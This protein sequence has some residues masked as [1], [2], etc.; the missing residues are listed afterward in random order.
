MIPITNPGHV[1]PLLYGI[2]IHCQFCI[3]KE[4]I[5]NAYPKSKNEQRFNPPT[6][7]YSNG[8]DPGGFPTTIVTSWVSASFVNL[9]RSQNQY[10]SLVIIQNLS[11]T[12]KTQNAKYLRLDLK[13]D[14]HSLY[15]GVSSAS[16]SHFLPAYLSHLNNHINP[17]R[18][19][20]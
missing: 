9:L 8:R 15:Q 14:I 11:P 18:H 10:Y 12:D 7:R 16:T 19:R 2:F 6:N 4:E 13:R 1:I 5:D 17:K 3:S 20:T